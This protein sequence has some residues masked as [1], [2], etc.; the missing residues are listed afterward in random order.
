MMR[1][2]RDRGRWMSND[3]FDQGVGRDPDRDDRE[4]E[5]HDDRVRYAERGRYGHDSRPYYEREQDRR[6]NDPERWAGSDP[7]PGAGYDDERYASSRE[8]Y[9]RE[10]LYD[11]H[12]REDRGFFDRVRD[13]VRSW[14]RDDDRRDHEERDEPRSGGDRDPRDLGSQQDRGYFPEHVDPRPYYGRG[15]RRY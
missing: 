14:F 2:P 13:R 3:E 15:R 9:S 10:A 12:E 11:R 8:V 1:D 5:R 6:P 7:D 4:R